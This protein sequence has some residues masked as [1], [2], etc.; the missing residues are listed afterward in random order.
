MNTKTLRNRR[1]RRTTVTLEADVAD[2][3]QD[4]LRKDKELKEKNLIN[5]LLRAGIKAEGD[6][7]SVEFKIRPFKTSLVDDITAK[8]IE[9]LLD[10][11]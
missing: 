2:F 10:E 3:I 7:K 11:I 8:D 6:K 5:G 4:A 1:T 9:A